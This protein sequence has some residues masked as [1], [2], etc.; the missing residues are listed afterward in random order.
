VRDAALRVLAAS[1]AAPSAEAAKAI[2]QLGADQST[3]V[4]KRALALAA[5]AAAA[6][7]LS[8]FCDQFLMLAAQL[9]ADEEDTV[10]AAAA[11]FFVG[12]L[13]AAARPA[14]DTDA[15]ACCR[16]LV[17]SLAAES[18]DTTTACVPAGSAHSGED[19]VAV[20]SGESPAALLANLPPFQAT[21]LL[22]QTTP[23]ALASA[24][25]AIARSDSAEAARRAGATTRG[26]STAKKSA[27]EA[28]ALMNPLA[29][30]AGALLD[31]LSH[32][33]VNGL[34]AAAGVTTETAEG[35]CALVA[36]RSLTVLYGIV[37]V[38]A[39]P[40]ASLS[41]LLLPYLRP[42]A[43][44]PTASGPSPPT[45]HPA[46][47]RAATVFGR[48]APAE[49]TAALSGHAADG[50][51]QAVRGMVQSALLS[52]RSLPDALA[53]G[54]ALWALA[55][56]GN[57]VALSEAQRL[58]AA[59][60]DR[61]TTSVLNPLEALVTTDSP[62]PHRLSEALAAAPVLLSSFVPPAM[63]ARPSPDTYTPLIARLAS[64]ASA[65]LATPETANAPIA[66]QLLST[67][68]FL[69]TA[70]P[71][72]VLDEPHVHHLLRSELARSC[73]P[74]TADARPAHVWTLRLVVSVLAA[75]E[76][77]DA[78]AR[79][80]VRSAVAL[81]D[82]PSTSG[83]SRNARDDAQRRTGSMFVAA[84]DNAAQQ[85]L[86]VRLVQMAFPV[87][88]QFL[89]HKFDVDRRTAA[90][91][92]VLLSARTGIWLPAALFP[93]AVAASADPS[94]A[95]RS[96][97]LQAGRLLVE[98]FPND[99]L[100]VL[101]AGVVLANRLHPGRG[102]SIALLP[103]LCQG[104]TIPQSRKATR[105]V[106]DSVLLALRLRDAF[107]GVDSHLNTQ[108]HASGDQAAIGT[109]SQ[110]TA[111]EPTSQSV[112]ATD[113]KLEDAATS[114]QPSAQGSVSVSAAS[115][116]RSG[117]VF[118]VL[119]A[120]CALPF[121]H[122]DAPLYLMCQLARAS[123]VYSS[124]ASAPSVGHR[125]LLAM[126]LAARS[127]VETLY[128]LAAR[129]VDYHPS[130]PT[131]TPLPDVSPQLRV[132]ALRPLIALQSAWSH[133]DAQVVDETLQRL[134]D[135]DLGREETA[136]AA[137][138]MRRRGRPP[139][140]ASTATKTTM[141]RAGTKRE[142]P[143]SLADEEDEA[144]APKRGARRQK[145]SDKDDDFVL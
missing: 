75:E 33:D 34:A 144:P 74:P 61:F 53:A 69:L 39:Q 37:E 41:W 60:V 64:V 7:P 32:L 3:S 16:D 98:S 31:A 65:Y 76:K 54:E 72:L 138:S 91:Q 17:L 86:S 113:V 13:R 123:A 83:R 18:C 45:L 145:W 134:L 56:A 63:R 122:D 97:A 108:L 118:D 28:L 121:A 90:A 49:R 141:R 105:A 128:S 77:L 117:L 62:L 57:T 6:A 78:A 130:K 10:S 99:S 135:D 112:G 36:G 11:D 15:A 29:L 4:K 68:T 137:P 116:L 46:F 140:K 70:A 132:A 101:G 48:I 136:R 87:V 131:D 93:M 73:R 2:R 111:S 82:D 67:L 129:A 58:T 55:E 66:Q 59:A 104:D 89:H 8:T 27:D 35:Y 51:S 84:E 12:L 25:V 115:S 106:I 107:E 109:Q 102:W 85:A 42:V 94:P 14:A 103:K 24:F 127:G 143:V 26:E 114:Q 1:A 92:V 23:A 142:A 52:M 47:R 81:A 79:A 95:V 133:G 139:G 100:P 110:P 50:V 43:S 88:R 30:R 22:G 119:A 19:D 21:L 96:L 40:V 9:C 20:L 80:S 120:L 124:A 38:D 71:S 126:L 125:A 44:T 5:K